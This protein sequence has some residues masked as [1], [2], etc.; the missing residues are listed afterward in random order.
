MLHEPLHAQLARLGLRGAA[1][2]LVR[3]QPDD[4]LLDALAL[5]LE[6]ESLHRDSLAQA[7]R[8]VDESFRVHPINTRRI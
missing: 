3:L 2:A 5:L 8:D 6:A 7:R 4:G 1:D